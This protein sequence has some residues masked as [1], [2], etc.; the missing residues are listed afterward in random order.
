[1]EPAHGV[2]DGFEHPL[3]LV[4]PS[5]V[6][7]ELYLRRREAAYFGGRGATLFQL[8]AHPQPL[9]RHLGEHALHVCLVDLVHRVPGVHQP[10]GKLTVVREEKRAGGVHVQT[11]HRNDATLVAD[12][13]DDGWSPVRI[14][15][16]CENAGG[17]VEEN[18]RKR[19]GVDRAAVDLDPVA[20]RDEG[21]QAR[22]VS[23]YANTARP[24]QLVGAATGS[25]SRAR[26]ISVQ[27][28]ST[29]IIVGGRR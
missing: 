13:L 23:V 6:D 18:V 21:R 12:E 11:P 14:P 26:E 2:S 22:H 15:C 8:D 7:H 19:L 5:L 24:D 25:K 1:M 9:E 27:P 29:P 16:G 28:H 10:M 20:R 3:Y 17:L 4:L